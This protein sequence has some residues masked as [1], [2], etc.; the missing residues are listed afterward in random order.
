MAMYS[1]P[2]SDPKTWENYCKDILRRFYGPSDMKDIPD[3][4][5]GDF[6]IECY[7]FSGHAFQCYI[8]EEI[9]DK[10]KI[11]KALKVKIM[12][13]IRKLTVT[14][15]GKFEKLFAGMSINRWILMTPNNFDS[16][17][18]LYCSAKSVKVRKLGLGYISDDFQIVVQ[19]EDDYKS[20]VR[21]LQKEEYQL[22]LDYKQ[23]C[24]NDAQSWLGEN[25]EFLKH[26]DRKVPKVTNSENVESTKNFLVQKFL[27]YQNLLDFLM[28]EFPDIHREIIGIVDNR[29]SYLESRFLTDADK[30]PGE[31]IKSEI[32]S[33]REDVKGSVETIKNSDLEL[34]EWGVV[35]DWLIRCPLDF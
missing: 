34:I 4:Y 23:I 29:R 16:E 28:G 19:T 2:K 7:S 27:E 14:N 6:G 15:I 24:T 35:S 9:L 31:V 1:D 22:S 13:D 33:L 18:A 32:K 11:T 5:A 8:P 10:G 20:E 30:L 3:A 17:M 21:S 25:Q 26:L 12:K